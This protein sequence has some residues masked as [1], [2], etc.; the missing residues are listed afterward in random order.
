[1]TATTPLGTPDLADLAELAEVSRQ[2]EDAPAAEIVAW[3][4]E[5]FGDGIVL[6]SSFQDC[7]L[8]DIALRVAPDLEVVFLDTGFH[9]AETLWF[10][11]RVQQRYRMNLTVMHP[12]VEVGDLW[13]L[14]VDSC[15]GARKVEPLARALEGRAAWMTAVRRVEA[16]TRATT[17]IVTYDIG[18][19]LV[20]V[21]PI[22]AWTDEQVDAYIADNDLPIHPLVDRGY[23]SIGCWPCTRPV[24]PGEDPRAGRWSGQSKTECGLHA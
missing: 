13:Q 22:A 19:G 11:D 6:A 21:N 20:K 14:D 1:M 24:A 7:V 2:F 5:R 15:C 3:A 18:R 12:A 17:P 9:F 8:L 23:P 10:A 16:P 4:T